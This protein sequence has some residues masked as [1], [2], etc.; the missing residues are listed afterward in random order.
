MLKI[1]L[2]SIDQ[3]VWKW[4]K[5]KNIKF[6]ENQE[7]LEKRLAW[8]LKIELSSIDQYVLKWS[9]AK[10]QE[11]PVISFFIISHG[12]LGGKESGTDVKN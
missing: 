8:M 1:E 11:S 5:A 10:N 9:K 12:T 6:Q 4:S 7:S 3:Y 2:S